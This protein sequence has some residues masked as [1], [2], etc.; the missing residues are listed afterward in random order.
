MTN[1]KRAEAKRRREDKMIEGWYYL[2]TNGDLIYKRDFP[3]IEADIRESSFARA[4]WPIDT[5]D[6]ESAWR[7][8]VEALAAGANVHRIDELAEKWFCDDDDAINYIERLGL[9]LSRDGNAWCVTRSDF[10]CLATDPAGFGD[11]IL[12]A[13]ADLC[14]QLGY[15]PSKMWGATFKDLCQPASKTQP[16]TASNERS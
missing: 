13:M 5:S 2:H 15:T 10:E 6:R 14:K 3:G 12:E 1:L 4:L 9:K 11:T 8:L 7:V 16:A